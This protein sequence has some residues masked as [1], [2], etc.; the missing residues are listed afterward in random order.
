M[1]DRV[2]NEAEIDALIEGTACDHAAR[3]SP[4]E[5][6][7]REGPQTLHEVRCWHL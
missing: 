2:L 3:R 5:I 1:N 4:A 7:L 6:T